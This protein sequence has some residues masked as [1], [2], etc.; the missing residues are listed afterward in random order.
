MFAVTRPRRVHPGAEIALVYLVAAVFFAVVA[1]AVSAAGSDL[2]VWALG[3]VFIAAVAALARW[4]GVQYAVPSAMAGLLAYDWYFFPPTHPKAFP[5]SEDL[6]NL[7][8][9]LAVVVLI[10]E[11]VAYAARAA[12]VSEI[13]RAGLAGEQ[14]ALRRVATLV[15]MQSAPEVVF[16]AVAREVGRLL[17]VDAT[18]MGCY[19][20]DGTTAR[21][22][23]WNRDG[24]PPGTGERWPVEGD[25]VTAR[26]LSTGAPARVDDYEGA[27]GPIAEMLRSEGIR[28]SVGV[29][30]VVDQQL[31]GV[32]IA[33][34]ESDDL[35]P[36]DTEERMAGFTELVAT[37]ISNT[38]ARTA[39][40]RLGD[41]QSA[42]RRVATLV[43]REPAPGD[44]FAA[45]TAEV[46]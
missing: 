32:M 26:V 46:G 7:L 8:G 38:E 44:V 10:G 33:S 15:A 30:I 35:L 21:I 17:D 22:A 6:L 25:S 11:L 24:T 3:V 14:A 37:A 42:L 12:E 1:V 43:A 9:Y 18:H 36:A 41:E 31:W 2:L 4:L 34:S 45:V 40:A 20:A 28:S 23:S 13:A 27:T 39:L 16:A 29:P 19:A 5:G